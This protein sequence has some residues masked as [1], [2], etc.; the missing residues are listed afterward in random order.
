MDQTPGDDSSAKTTTLTPADVHNVAFKRSQIGK[1]G[2]DEEEVDNFLDVVEAELSR[3]IEENQSIKSQAGTGAL[4]SSQLSQVNDQ[5]LIEEN[6]RLN[7]ALAQ[8]QQEHG[9]LGQNSSQLQDALAAA[10]QRA[11]AAEQR[12]QAAE[13][14][15]A[16]AQA[17]AAEAVRAAGDGSPAAAPV[18]SA[19]HHQQA[20]KV[21]AL[22]QQ[23]ADQHLAGAQADAERMVS[24]ATAAANKLES[25]STAAA[26]QRVQEAQARADA[27]GRD[28]EAKAAATVND[29]EQRAAAINSALETRKSALERRLEELRTFEREYRSRL[30][31]YLESQLRDLEHGG[32]PDA[33]AAPAQEAQ[34]SDNAYHS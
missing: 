10:E 24:E 23:T 27:L 6:Q 20:V 17:Q 1:R 32:D 25:E 33:G 26:N 15:A 8:L 4:D 18:V 7:A 11:Q 21:L 19:D 3:L 16:Q 22:A 28:S 9:N 29:A 30:K 14:A 13:Q 34:G 5:T 2:Y 31:S 12:V